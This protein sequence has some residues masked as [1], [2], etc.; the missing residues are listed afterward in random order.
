MPNCIL[1]PHLFCRDEYKNYTEF[2]HAIRDEILHHVVGLTFH[3]KI[4][5][6]QNPEN[7]K[8]IWHII[9]KDTNSSNNERSIDRERAEH[10]PW[11][12][13]LL[14][15]E[16][17]TCDNFLVWRKRHKRA[18]RWCIYCPKEK[19]VVILEE[20][21]HDELILITAFLVTQQR[22]HDFQKEYNQYVK[23]GI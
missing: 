1:L 15:G 6:L 7:Y 3:Q 19:Y 13:F 4:I 14:S 18:I 22:D 17:D 8:T 23:N 11:I 9:T 20:R 21:G 10:V 16:C 12:R 5:R 2:W